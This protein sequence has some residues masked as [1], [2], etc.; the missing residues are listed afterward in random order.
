MTIRLPAREDPAPR[1]GTEPPQQLTQT[2]PAHC[3]RA[4]DERVAA[5][6]GVRVAASW[7]CHEGSVACHLIP[8]YAHGPA[9]A[10]FEGTEFAHRHPAYDGSL[11][12]RLDDHWTAAV[13]A[14]GWGVSVPPGS[15][16]GV[17]LY[18]PRDEAETEV[19]WQLLHASY[20][21][22]RRGL[23]P[24]PRQGNPAVLRP[25]GTQR[26]RPGRR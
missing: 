20:W 12:V 21:Y 6:H 26:E 10:F 5:L 3:Q 25:A 19:L 4:L 23:T 9:A 22:A 7:G 8:R 24:V 16:G 13:V 2:A 18:G 17:L 15:G 14:A 1:I 11:H